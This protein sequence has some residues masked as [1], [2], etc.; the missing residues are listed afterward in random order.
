MPKKDS[1][2]KVDFS[3][4]SRVGKVR[5]VI[6][7]VVSVGSEDEAIMVA[8]QHTLLSPTRWNVSAEKVA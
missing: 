7:T 4:K 1:A 6:V 2:F 8:K 5:N 3:T